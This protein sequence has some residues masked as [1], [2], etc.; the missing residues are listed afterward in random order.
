MANPNSVTAQ[1][2]DMEL[3]QG[4]GFILDTD[5][6]VRMVSGKKAI[7]MDLIR[8]ILVHKGSWAHDEEFGSN[9]YLLLQS[10]G[11]LTVAEEDIREEIQTAA[12]RMLSDQR[13][14]EIRSVKIIARTRSQITIELVV[15]ISDEATEVRLNLPA[16]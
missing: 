5:N 8:C 10:E 16:I 14:E 2:I 9:L 11:T 1:I 6:D 3:N 13:I 4:Q 15:I 12:Q 7:L